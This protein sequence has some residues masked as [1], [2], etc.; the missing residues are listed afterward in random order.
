VDAHLP[1]F[2]SSFAQSDTTLRSILTPQ[3]DTSRI[4]QDSLEKLVPYL[5]DVQQRTSSSS[6]PYIYMLV[7]ALSSLLSED[8]AA[9]GAGLMAAQ[10]LIDFWPA[11]FGAIAGI[12]IG[13]FSLY[14]A[15]R[16]LG[17]GVFEVAPFKWFLKKETIIS[18]EKWF[19]K[20]GPVILVMS[21]FIPG[22]RFP[23]Y[24]SAGLLKTSFWKFCLYFGVTV[25]IWT[26]I[27]VWL[28]VFAGNEILSYYDKYDD[29]AIWIMIA[30]VLILFLLYKY[31]LPLLTRRGRK[32][33]WSKIQRWFNQ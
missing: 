7:I 17:N 19:E 5:D 9:I 24:L 30:A 25:L 6:Y 18:A 20:K 27:F 33:A 15:G 13:D 31:L 21:R 1:N 28:S 3:V 2:T 22:S 26:P 12:F 4:S 29:Y 16:I 32:I 11:V 14:F 23:V 8:L 10:G